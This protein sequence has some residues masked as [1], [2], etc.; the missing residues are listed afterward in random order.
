MKWYSEKKTQT[1]RNWNTFLGKRI[2]EVS[3]TSFS[4]QLSILTLSNTGAGQ[5]NVF[6]SWNKPGATDSN[7]YRRPH[8]ECEWLTRDEWDMWQT[9]K[10]RRQPHSP[11]RLWTHGK[12]DSVCQVLPVFSREAMCIIFYKGYAYL[13]ML[14]SN[15][16]LLKQCM[17]Q[18]RHFMG[19]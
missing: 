14:T 18:S 4:S 2:A 12:K 15:L 3:W 19:L 16:G 6:H 11:N 7:S 10:Q 8:K 17:N 1:R 5:W 9:R 13:N